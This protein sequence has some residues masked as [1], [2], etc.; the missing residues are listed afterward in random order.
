M[1]LDKLKI[2]VTKDPIHHVGKYGE[3]FFGENSIYEYPSKRHIKPYQHM[4]ILHTF[5]NCVKAT[6][7][8]GLSPS[9]VDWGDPIEEP[10][11]MLKYTSS[12]CMLMEVDWRG[13]L[14][15]NYTS[16]GYMLMEV[17]CGGNLI[18]NSI[19]WGTHKTDPNAQNIYEVDWGGHGSSSNHMTEFLLDRI[20]STNPGAEP[21]RDARILVQLGRIQCT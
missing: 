2:E 7:N 13:N 3:H 12:G 20:P 9:E 6:F 8:H 4:E 10:T 11:K 21:P 17:D 1:I 18:L 19:D 15:F 14:N 5:S 16:C